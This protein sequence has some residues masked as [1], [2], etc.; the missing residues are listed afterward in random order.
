M[1]N[2]GIFSEG[3]GVALT[4]DGE[5]WMSNGPGEMKE[6]SPIEENAVGDVLIFGLGMGAII[7]PMLFNPDIT[8]I[9][10][11]EINS[12]VIDLVRPHLLIADREKKLHVVNMSAYDFEPH[13][14]YDAIW[15]DIDKFYSD[16]KLNGPGLV[17]KFKPYLNDGGWIGAWV[18]NQDN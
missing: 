12:E 17:K 3:R 4:I 10:I 8:S 7:Y 16:A 11:I 13:M 2:V 5:V 15:V 6:C 14:S 18:V 9:T 1:S